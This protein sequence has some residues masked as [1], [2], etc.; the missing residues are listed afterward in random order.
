MAYSDPKSG[1]SANSATFAHL[2]SNPCM[3]SDVIG[4]FAE[5]VFEGA[6]AP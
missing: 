2:K 3:T 5:G 4:D 1:A 6:R